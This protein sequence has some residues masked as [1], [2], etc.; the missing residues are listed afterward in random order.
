MLICIQCWPVERSLE[1]AAGDRFRAA[2]AFCRR[3][4]PRMHA[5][6]PRLLQAQAPSGAPAFAYRPRQAQVRLLQ[7]QLH[8]PCIW[9]ALP[10]A[11]A[12]LGMRLRMHAC[13]K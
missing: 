11:R 1:T 4:C 9:C 10:P 8:A 2:C 5:C 13:M 12:A 3:T 6:R 7:A